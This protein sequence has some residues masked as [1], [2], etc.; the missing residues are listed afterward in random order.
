MWLGKQAK[1]LVVGT[2]SRR[3]DYLQLTGRHS[4]DPWVIGT[5]SYRLQL[6]SN[7]L[8]L[9]GA[10]KGAK[11]MWDS[12]IQMRRPLAHFELVIE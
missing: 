12:S 3:F 11:G 9:Q 1:E 4:S 5:D 2:I 7:G 6:S 10:S 8:H